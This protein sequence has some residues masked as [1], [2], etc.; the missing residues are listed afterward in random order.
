MVPAPAGLSRLV[1]DALENAMAADHIRRIDAR[2]A[3][4][5]LFGMMRGVNRYRAKDDRLED[6]VTAVVDI[7]M[8]GVGT[9]A[10]RQVL[11]P[12]R[13]RRA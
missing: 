1:Q 8:R 9:P 2:I 5:M 3:T 11:A 12:P 7:F 13:V 10:G 6:V 4:E